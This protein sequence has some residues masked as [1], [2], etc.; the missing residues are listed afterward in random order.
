MQNRFS[1][2]RSLL[3]VESWKHIPGNE[4]PADLPFRRT[5][6]I[7]HV[8]NMLCRD[9]PQMSLASDEQSDPDIPS[10]CFKEL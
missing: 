10:E 4:N 6:P 3:A 9:G 5:T 7:E 8:V 2:I 1:E